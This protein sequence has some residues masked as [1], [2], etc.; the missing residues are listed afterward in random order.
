MSPF[1]VQIH[2]RRC[3]RHTGW[4]VR[5]QALLSVRTYAFLG[6]SRPLRKHS[7]ILI[8]MLKRSPTMHVLH[9]LLLSLMTFC[10]ASSTVEE[11]TVLEE[12]TT[13]HSAVLIVGR[14]KRRTNSIFAVSTLISC[15]QRGFMYCIMLC[16]YPTRVWPVLW[17]VSTSRGPV[18]ESIAH[19]SCLA[20][21]WMQKKTYHGLDSPYAPD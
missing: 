11:L 20:L 16:I 17:Q 7:S 6:K 1:E 19:M 4:G 15:T 5:T 3:L 21:Y 8:A 18:A 13:P 12:T 2:P 10:T 14:L 9:A